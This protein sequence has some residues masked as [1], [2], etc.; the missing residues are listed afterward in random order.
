MPIAK[1]GLNE[2]AKQ[3]EARYG[4]RDGWQVTLEYDTF[5][6][7]YQAAT[8]GVALTDVSA[9]GKLWIQGRG[10]DETMKHIFGINPDRPTDLKHFA[11]GW[12]TQINHQEYYAIVPLDQLN[13][14]IL[15]LQQGFQGQHAHVTSVTHSKDI[16]AV[17]GPQ[18]VS[19]L[20]KICALN[21]ENL[22]EETAQSGRLAQVSAIVV[23]CNLKHLPCYEIHLDR[24]Y[25][26]YVLNV[27]LDAAKE[28]NG[29][30]I[31]L[32][33]LHILKEG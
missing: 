11:N 20:G 14:Y 8:Q 4:V 19:V 3:L 28:F 33:A 30:L 15:Q 23:R 25:S 12:I 2:R 32:D 18:A 27:L 16:I 26:E 13:H 17:F 22:D 7:A 24:S 5:D 29:Q 9:V 10:I 31:G 1:N 6:L 21:I